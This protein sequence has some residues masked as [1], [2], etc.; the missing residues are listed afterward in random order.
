VSGWFRH[1]LGFTLLLSHAS[2]PSACRGQGLGWTLARSMIGGH[3][4]SIWSNI[5]SRPPLRTVLETFASHGSSK[6]L[7]VR[8]TRPRQPKRCAVSD[9]WRSCRVAPWVRLLGFRFASNLSLGSQSSRRTLDDSPDPRQQPFGLG[10]TTLSAGLWIPRA[11]RQAAF[12][13]W[14]FMSPLWSSAFLPKIVGPT[15]PKPRPQRDC[16]VSHQ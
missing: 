6:S 12:A 2:L 11:F 14:I 9:C 5:A 7:T 4:H 8:G 10:Q 15:G 13:S 3:A 16:R 1:S